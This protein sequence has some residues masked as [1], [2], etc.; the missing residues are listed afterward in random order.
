[1]VS[2]KGGRARASAPWPADKVQR[3]PIEDLIPYADN[4]RLHTDAQVD[5]I[6]RS[7]RQFGF[8]IPVLVR[9]DGTIIAGH[10]RVLAA[11][12]LS[13]AEVP[14]MVATGWSDEQ[15][16]AYAIADN[17]LAEN[18]SWDAERL[19][20]EIMALSDIGA[21]LS[22]IGF[23]EAE[24]A[25]YLEPGADFLGDIKVEAPADDD[26]PDPHVVA[27]GV[28]LNLNF[29]PEERDRVVRFLSRERES[30]GLK[31]IAQ[32]LLALADE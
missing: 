11:R 25:G 32:A 20:R 5:Q 31:T 30:R 6:A 22:G 27:R 16:R 15:C 3:W 24:I 8:T 2:R 26:D 23:T 17:R 18:S 7:I 4:A 14:V 19:A 10:G 9:E 28:T 12:T 29:L 1:M 13:L 21:D